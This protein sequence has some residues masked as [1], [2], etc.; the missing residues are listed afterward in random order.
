MLEDFTTACCL[1]SRVGIS[2]G[3]LEIFLVDPL[4]IWCFL[5]KGRSWLAFCNDIFFC[6]LSNAAHGA[7][8]MIPLSG[9]CKYDIFVLLLVDGSVAR[10][11]R[12][13]LHDLELVLSFLLHFIFNFFNSE[14]SIIF[15]IFRE[16]VPRP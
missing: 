5:F 7:H 16:I 2:V 12:H 11:I 1:L 8:R 15:V 3:S 6:F 9:V 4:A 10:E 14:S 13:R